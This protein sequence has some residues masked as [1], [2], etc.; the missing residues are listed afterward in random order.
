MGELTIS[1]SAFK[2]M[3]IYE[4]WWSTKALLSLRDVCKAEIFSYPKAY[5]FAA[6]NTLCN[7]SFPTKPLYSMM[8]ICFFHAYSFGNLG[9]GNARQDLR[10][11]HGDRGTLELLN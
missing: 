3:E 7:D 4:L 1:G 9:L 11:G 6:L 5:D 8:H 10:K 2:V